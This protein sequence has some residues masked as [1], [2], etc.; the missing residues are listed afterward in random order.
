MVHRH[1]GW[2]FHTNIEQNYGAVVRIEEMFKVNISSL[3]PQLNA[4]TSYPG[5]QQRA[6]YVYDP[7]AL[8]SIILKDQHTYRKPDLTEL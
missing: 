2:D 4:M 1:H 7:K 3:V 8:H 6:L 5:S